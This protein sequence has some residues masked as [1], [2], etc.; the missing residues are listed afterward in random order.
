MISNFNKAIIFK[1]TSLHVFDPV[2]QDAKIISNS[3]GCDSHRSI[4]NVGNF[5]IFYNRK[6]VYATN[7]SDVQLI[8]NPVEKFIDAIDQDT[9]YEICAGVKDNKYYHLFIG[10]VTVNGTS[11]TNCELVYDVLQNSWTVNELSHK[12]TVYCNYTQ[13]TITT[14]T[15]TVTTSSSSSSSSSISS[16]TSSQST[17][18][19]SQTTSSSSSSTSSET[20]SSSSESS[21]SE[22]TSSSSE[23]TSSSSSSSETTSSTSITSE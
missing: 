6:G 10:D 1:N 15:S 5:T 3:I 19:S 11:Y 23:T 13:P 12:V 21:T 22:S 4:Q 7:G 17:S 14:T 18:S 8:S 20:T 16:S 2:G 9:V